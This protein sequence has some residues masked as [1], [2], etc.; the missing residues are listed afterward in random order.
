[1]ILVVNS[2]PLTLF[3]LISMSIMLSAGTKLLSKK[4]DPVINHQI[5]WLENQHNELMKKFKLLNNQEFISVSDKNQIQEQLTQS[6]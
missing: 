3:S 2:V 4:Y 5:N 1:M 6:A